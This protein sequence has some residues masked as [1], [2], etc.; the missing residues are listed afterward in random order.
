MS[1]P[2]S[3]RTV[4]FNPSSSAGARS[5]SR[6]RFH[7]THWSVVFRAGDTSRQEHREALETLF[8]TYWYPLYAYTR[9]SG[10]DRSNA[11]DATQAFFV[12]VLEDNFVEDADP[13]KGKFRSFLL[14][15]FK[16]F[17]ANRHA[18]ENTMRRGGGQKLLSLD[19]E[20]SEQRYAM[21]PTENW[22][23]DRLFD[24]QWAITLLNRVMQ[25]LEESYIGKG[26]QDLFLGLRR[27]LSGKA[28]GDSDVSYEDLA[29][30]L[31]M[32]DSAVR[33]AIHRMRVSYRE[34][35][36]E[37]IA[38]T[39]IDPAEVEGEIRFLRNA[40]RGD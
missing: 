24:R 1:S 39:L 5:D 25:L 8:S 37:E 9:R 16:R 19:F 15:V 32:T 30:R 2:D 38:K 23:A 10:M 12:K 3:N 13:E 35:L 17:L 7:S 29:N 4:E 33:V 34:I 31:G 40:I 22:T 11:E 27:Y 20:S 26:K 21:E 36:H 18:H 14:V 6:A 28:S